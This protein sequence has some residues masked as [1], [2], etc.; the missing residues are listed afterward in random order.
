MRESRLDRRRLLRKGGVGATILLAGCVD[1]ITGGGEEVN[2][3]PQTTEAP[4]TPTEAG[5]TGT[6][7]NT[8]DSSP[9]P[10]EEKQPWP[11]PPEPRFIVDQSGGGDYER[12]QDA[13]NV[14]RSGDAIGIASGEYVWNY[15][16]GSQT[17]L[18]RLNLVGSGRSETTIRINWGRSDF[19]LENAIPRF[20]STT[21]TWASDA[22]MSAPPIADEPLAIYDSRIAAPIAGNMDI[23]GCTVTSDTKLLSGAIRHSK[24][25]AQEALVADHQYVFK[26]VF[27]GRLNVG[28]ERVA[29]S[30]DSNVLVERC[31]IAKLVTSEN[32]VDI[33]FSTI[34]PAPD[35]VALDH[36]GT[37]EDPGSVRGST[38]IGQVSKASGDWVLN[39]LKTGDDNFEY[40]IDGNGPQIMVGNAFTGADVRL[41]GSVTM[42]S[43]KHKLGN[44]YSAWN[45]GDDEDGDDVSELPRPIPGPSDVVDQHPL[46]TSDL[47][48]FEDTLADYY[49]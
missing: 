46:L 17:K 35:G 33:E 42:Y 3:P 36:S 48:K 44:Y 4:D 10:T 38:I 21:L 1:Q 7:E 26:S 28:G 15:S 37:E 9:T 30:L 11:D 2:P 43:S 45:G 41:T 5:E 24:V 25:T 32:P 22:G 31:Q 49:P 39:R 47:S 18:N 29:D 13:V 20:W 14:A 8:D 27:T 19:E 40:F 6:Q 12:L 16:E 23:V 34:G